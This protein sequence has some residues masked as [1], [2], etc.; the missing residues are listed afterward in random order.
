MPVVGARSLVTV[1]VRFPR[2]RTATLRPLTKRLGLAASLL[3]QPGRI[4]RNRAACRYLCRLR[5]VATVQHDTA[6][7]SPTV[8]SF[9]II[10]DADS[11]AGQMD[12]ADYPTIDPA[13]QTLTY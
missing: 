11:F 12:L 8:Q 4:R 6:G 2:G 1:I 5:V 13:T 10:P 9:D 7:R 3:A